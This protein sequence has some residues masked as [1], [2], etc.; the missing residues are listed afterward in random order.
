MA[1]M[2]TTSRGKDLRGCLVAIR[3]TR[4]SLRA[5]EQ[6]VADH[7][8]E[9]P[10]DVI[11]SSVSEVARA[12]GT[13]DAT[14][15]RFCRA[16]GYRGFPEMKMVLT[17]DLARQDEQVDRAVALAPDDSVAAIAR[18]VFQC[19][20]QALMDTMELQQASELE[21]AVA[22][23]A[24]AGRIMLCGVGGSAP[25]AL[26]AAHKL[27]LIGLDAQAYS[28]PHMQR[29]AMCRL[30]AGDV[31]LGISHSGEAP[32]VVR[33][34][35]LAGERGATTIGITNYAYSSLSRIVTI[36][37]CTASAEIG[38]TGSSV[39]SRLAQVGLIDALFL[40]V[41]LRRHAASV[42]S[43]ARITQASP[44]AAK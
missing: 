10:G 13:S 38:I 9:Q 22:A 35:A 19:N 18:Y 5:A 2:S 42:E 41:A 39:A 8:L 12:A 24:Q 28:D 11:H 6:R 25:I 26:E 1:L 4:G 15:V 36:P 16:L 21:R 27:Q 7:V 37:L 17:R 3:A 29:I 40:A 20:I 31:A 14:V 34:L 44:G 33:A 32:D 43:L 30:A 23:L